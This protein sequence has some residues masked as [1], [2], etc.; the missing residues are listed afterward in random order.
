MFITE[1]V[2]VC[3]ICGIKVWHVKE[4]SLECWSII[5]VY[6]KCKV[7]LP[8]KINQKG[9]RYT[10]KSLFRKMYYLLYIVLNFLM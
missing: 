3:D 2:V 8:C 4:Q 6:D 1:V 7:Y 5:I 9:I 10:Y